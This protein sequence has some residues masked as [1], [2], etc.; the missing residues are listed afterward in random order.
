MVK[1][2]ELTKKVRQNSWVYWRDNDCKYATYED[3]AR[4]EYKI[5]VITSWTSFSSFSHTI[6][7]DENDITFFLL[8]WS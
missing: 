3:W 1:E 7:G 8:R 2:I 6:E 5:N 4:N